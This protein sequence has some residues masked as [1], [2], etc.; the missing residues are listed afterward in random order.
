MVTAKLAWI[1]CRNAHLTKPTRK[2]MAGLRKSAPSKVFLEIGIW[3]L[4][5]LI[6]YKNLLEAIVSGDV[7]GCRSENGGT[8]RRQLD[9]EAVVSREAFPCM[10][11]GWMKGEYRMF[12]SESSRIR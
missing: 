6:S 9:F 3:T 7:F 11:N 8:V 5:N 2:Q 10:K 12:P 4:S 1:E